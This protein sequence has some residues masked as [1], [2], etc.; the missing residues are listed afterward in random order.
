MTPARDL[1]GLER[2]TVLR[3]FGVAAAVGVLPA[4]CGGIAD[5]L[6]P[7]RGPELA[8]LSARH[9]AVLTAAALRIVGPAGAP[10]IATRTVD[11][12]R[13]ADAWLARTPAL[14]AP[15]GQ[16]LTLLEFGTW[17]LVG[18]A[19]LF[20]A[21]DDA[22]RDRVLAEC[23]GSRLELKRSVFRGIR[24][25]VLLVFYGHEASRPLTGYPGPFGTGTVTIADA[26]RD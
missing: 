10:L 24:S 15:M 7:G 25:L 3:L 1:R 19:R 13:L 9:Y 20:T 5:D 22:G 12:G 23:M 8:M 18:K 16:A 6:G 2:R 14:A 21:L 17:P 11:V 4:G 26:M